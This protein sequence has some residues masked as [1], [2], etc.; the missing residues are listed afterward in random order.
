M[1]KSYFAL[2]QSQS[3]ETTLMI[4]RSFFYISVVRSLFDP[5]G[6]INMLYEK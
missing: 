2:G 4:I 1:I 5:K 3:H 6:G